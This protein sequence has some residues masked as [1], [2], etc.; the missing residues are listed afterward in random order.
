MVPTLWKAAARLKKPLW[1]RH[2]RTWRQT[3]FSKHSHH[4]VSSMHHKKPRGRSGPSLQ[5]AL[6]SLPIPTHGRALR[7]FDMQIS[8][9]IHNQRCLQLTAHSEYPTPSAS[10]LPKHHT[11]AQASRQTTQVPA[12]FRGSRRCCLQSL[13][14][15]HTA[16]PW[17]PGWR[18]GAYRK[19]AGWGCTSVWMGGV[20]EELPAGCCRV[21]SDQRLTQSVISNRQ[22]IGPGHCQLSGF[23]CKP[24]ATWDFLEVLVPRMKRFHEDFFCT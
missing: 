23:Y 6:S 17:P 11:A 3:P 12:V 8:H 1:S 22:K 24:Q 18:W 13:E 14:L 20:A 21:P 19:D 16:S 9:R 10:S 4:L 7:C 15:Q 2:S 5:Q